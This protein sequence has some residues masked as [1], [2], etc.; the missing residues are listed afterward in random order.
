MALLPH[1]TL[2]LMRV[3][4]IER[5]WSVLRSARIWKG[6]LAALWLIPF[7]A[8]VSATTERVHQWDTNSRA[9]ADYLDRHAASGDRVCA[10]P[11]AFVHV[12]L[13]RVPVFGFA[14]HHWP[15]YFSS[16]RREAERLAHANQAILTAPSPDSAMRAISLYDV[17]WLIL[18][19]DDPGRPAWATDCPQ[20]TPASSTGRYALWKVNTRAVAG[21]ETAESEALDHPPIAAG[22]Q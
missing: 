7:L 10:T 5:L 3:Q 2:G 22:T 21:A 6:A 13:G 14:A 16:P 4:R 19:K 8:S 11:D 20:L 1:A 9:L 12:A 17:K 15:L 18:D